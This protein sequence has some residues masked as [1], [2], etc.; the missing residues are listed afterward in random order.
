MF[1]RHRRLSSYSFLFC[2]F[3]ASLFLYM[4][5]RSVLKWPRTLTW[6]VRR[7]IATYTD[8]YI[9]SYTSQL[10]YTWQFAMAIASSRFS[11]SSCSFSSFIV[12]VYLHEDWCTYTRIHICI[13]IY[14]HIHIDYRRACWEREMRKFSCYCC[15]FSLLVIASEQSFSND[16]MG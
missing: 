10:R 3:L 11:L 2:F 9:H 16:K 12:Y 13:Y 7:D 4:H 1:A 15:C 6:S 8:T 5:T 14:T